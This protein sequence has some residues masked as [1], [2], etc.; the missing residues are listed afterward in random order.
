MIRFLFC[1]F[2]L[3]IAICSASRTPAEMQSL[4][5]AGKDYLFREKPMTDS[6][7][8]CFETVADS[9]F[10]EMSQKQKELCGTAANNLGFTY[11]YYVADY[12]KAY[13]ALLHALE[14][15]NETGKV[16]TTVNV[17]LN[18]GNVYLV[19]SEHSNSQALSKEAEDMYINAFET[20]RTNGLWHQMLT[21]FANL[22]SIRNSF[23]HIQRFKN[24]IDEYGK[25]KIAPSTAN[26]KYC[27]L[28]YRGLQA[29]LNYDFIKATDYLK[30]HIDTIDTD[31]TV[32]A[33]RSQAITLVS[34]VY[35]LRQMPDSAL[36][37]AR[38]LLD[39]AVQYDLPETTANAYR[40]LEKYYSQKGDSVAAKESH[41]NY[42]V[43]QDSLLNY[44][45]LGDVD[46]LKFINE[47][48]SEKEKA[49]ILLAEAD[50]KRKLRE[51]ILFF[52]GLILLIII[53]LL[54]AV[55]NRHRKLR[56]SYLDLYRKQQ[57]ILLKEEEERRQRQA[58]LQLLT[59]PDD[60]EQISYTAPKSAISQKNRILAVLD[61]TDEKFSSDFSLERLSE[62]VGINPRA[63][64]AV[65]ND[66]LGITFRELL[67]RY[68][69]REACRRLVDEDT[70]G[71]LTIE[72]ISES[73]GYKSRTSLISAFKRETGLT[74]SEYQRAARHT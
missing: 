67:N 10:P 34:A 61:S 41:I 47:L 51:L 65:L 33:Y 12:R 59:K 50:R 16:L 14:I 64:S 19:F 38:S 39:Y 25:T 73:V 9:Y 69:V 28:R 31:V 44:C 56:R 24:I 70:Y 22:T 1:V 13:E 4:I 48:A 58:Q 2:S 8:I 43:A 20:A 62:L 5:E 68:R 54:M 66:S 49:S 72:A 45:K 40:L 37:Y 17:Y 55:L 71:H 63:L 29:I 23:N 60:K 11:F 42:I 18:L 53:P 27:T 15:C 7:R 36:F 74:P 21:A 32:H 52:A 57:E 6:A 3:T 35:E 46:N 30:A 26:Y